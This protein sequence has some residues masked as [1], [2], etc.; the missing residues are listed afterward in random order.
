MG[1]LIAML[2]QLR[3]HVQCQLRR[4]SPEV[5]ILGIRQLGFCHVGLTSSSSSLFLPCWS[6]KL[7]KLALQVSTRGQLARRARD[8]PA[9]HNARP[10]SSWHQLQ[11]AALSVALGL[12]PL[13]SI[14]CFIF[15]LVS[16]VST[17]RLVSSPSL[18]RLGLH[19]LPEMCCSLVLVTA[20]GDRLDLGLTHNVAT[21]GSI[22]TLV[23]LLFT[24]SL[25]LLLLLLLAGD[26]VVPLC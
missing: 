2:A 15:V 8:V 26:V 22:L 7:F 25:L 23:A 10:T 9:Q 1:A 19:P 16:Q 13:T 24:F 6:H 5:R 17:F 20:G 4:L 21:E 11:A 14:A 18:P 3:P 12:G